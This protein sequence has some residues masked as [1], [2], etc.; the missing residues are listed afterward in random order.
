MIRFCRNNI[1]WI[2][3]VVFFTITFKTNFI[4]SFNRVTNFQYDSEDLAIGALA[5]EHYHVRRGWQGLGRLITNEK[6]YKWGSEKIYKEN[7]QSNKG[8]RYA[9]YSSQIGLQGKVY[10][11]IS[12]YIYSI[13]LIEVLRWLNCFVL[14]MVLVFICYLMKNKFGNLFASIWGVVFLLSPW[15][16]N[17][18]PNLYWVEFTWFIPMLIGLMA[19]SDKIQFKYKKWVLSIF[20]FISVGIK[21][22]C[23]YE[24]L[25]TILIAMIMFPLSD[26]LHSYFTKKDYNKTRNN[27]KTIIMFSLTAILAFCV[28]I[29]VHG[30]FRGNGDITQGIKN[31]YHQDILRRT[32]IGNL[33]NFKTQ[34]PGL[35]KSLNATIPEVLQ[36]YFDFYSNAYHSNIVLGLDGRYF[37]T[38]TALAVLLLLIRYR[39]SG[40]LQI[41]KDQHFYLLIISLLATLS[42]LILAK[43]H[44]YVH[45]H[46]NYVLWYFGYVQMCLFIIINDGLM[47]LRRFCCHC[48]SVEKTK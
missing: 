15:I 38:M 43:S 37:N 9:Q 21:A 24:Y 40:Y 1:W 26:L 47:Y 46:M 16:V 10:A 3:L 33:Q 5:A 12:K 27:L 44:S 13:D 39:K 8:L 14:S 30:K 11:K 34:H 20:I 35:I 41:I 48:P 6:N 4:D 2:V 25:S 31:I 17:F 19:V 7:R 18:A 29:S 23:G 32:A 36:K 42:W 45:V 22:A 28:V